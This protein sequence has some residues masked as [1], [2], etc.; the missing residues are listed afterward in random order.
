[1]IGLGPFKWCEGWGQ[2]VLQGMGLGHLLH[3]VGGVADWAI[4][5]S[6]LLCSVFR[7]RAS[8]LIAACNPVI[9]GWF[10]LTCY[11]GIVSLGCLCRTCI[12]PLRWS[13]VCGRSQFGCLLGLTW[14]LYVLMLFLFSSFFLRRFKNLS[15]SSWHLVVTVVLP[16]SF[17]LH[18]S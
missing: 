7:R 12:P 3:G 9:V 8:L 11:I 10:S 4:R 15:T 13:M 2:W 1:M 16:C 5:R 14:R 6:Q 17:R 18:F